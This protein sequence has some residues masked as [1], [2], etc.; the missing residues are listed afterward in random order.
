MK[1]A[2]ALAG[3]L[4]MLGA[5]VFAD[6]FTLGGYM[7]TGF[8][9]TLTGSKTSSTQ[10]YQ[11][12]YYYALGSRTRLNMSFDNSD[13]TAG[14]FMR[15]QADGDVTDLSV[16][17]LMGYDT[18]FNGYLTVA[19]GKLHDK[20][21]MT[22]WNGD[23]NFEGNYGAT[24]VITP[25]KGLNLLATVSSD[26]A[27]DF[28]PNTEMNSF[29][30][31][32]STDGIS[33]NGGYS[34]AKT[35]YASVDF[36]G[37]KGI[38]AYA[39]YNY[40]GSDTDVSHDVVQWV[41]FNL[42]NNLNFGFDLDEALTNSTLDTFMVNPYVQYT[43]SKIVSASL[44]GSYTINFASSTKNAIMVSPAVYLAGPADAH[45]VIWGEFDHSKADGSTYTIG[46]GIKKNLSLSV[47]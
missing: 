11:G 23:T 46:T 3:S 41:D 31:A 2:L 18:L 5:F 21:T 39:E 43:F 10:T 27:D 33:V 32:Y 20:W 29:S 34:L 12:G 16:E 40:D 36:T 9:S 22:A 15:L 1:K 19:A 47:K 44:E 24:A 26:S 28:G 35:G 37:V 13:N 7:R 14:L 42:V 4:V 45:F 30:A 8:D 6:G 38:E 17:S 25:I